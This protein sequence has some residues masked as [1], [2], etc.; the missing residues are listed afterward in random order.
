MTAL[1]ET[2]RFISDITSPIL[3]N[4]KKA[5]HEGIPAIHYAS[6]QGS[7]TWVMSLLSLGVSP[8][9]RMPKTFGTPLHFAA[10]KGHKD[11][12]LCLIESNADINATD[13]FGD[14]PLHVAVQDGMYECVEEL[15]KHGADVDVL[16]RN[17]ESP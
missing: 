12:V 7:L 8:N 14:A 9:L 13:L 16:N 3:T 2:S 15:I 11:I 1:S 10:S 4:L 17:G 6:S 5:D